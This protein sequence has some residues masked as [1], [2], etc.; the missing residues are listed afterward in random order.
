[1]KSIHLIT[2]RTRKGWTQEDLEA[3]TEHRGHRVPQAVI[4]KLERNPDAKPTFDTVIR[5]ADALEVEPRALRF[6]PVPDGRV[7]A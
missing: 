1:V 3:E 7:S 2:A 4:S 5:L 6:G